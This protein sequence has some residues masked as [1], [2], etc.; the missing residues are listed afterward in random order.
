MG[1][2]RIRGAVL[3]AAFAALFITIHLKLTYAVVIL[4]L[5]C[6]GTVIDQRL[7][8]RRNARQSIP[9]PP[10]SDGPV[11]RETHDLA[12]SILDAERHHR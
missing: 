10:S 5:C 7:Q 11:D 12:S 3:G 6:L 1:W 2:R 8:G 4:A 9:P